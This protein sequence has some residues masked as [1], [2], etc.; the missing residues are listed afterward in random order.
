[1][2]NI[3]IEACW[4]SKSNKQVDC[5]DRG[6]KPTHHDG[7]DSDKKP[8]YHS[9]SPKPKV[10][11]TNNSN[12]IET[13]PKS[14]TPQLVKPYLSLPEKPSSF[15]SAVH[16]IAKLITPD[17]FTTLELAI[18]QDLETRNLHIVLDKLNK[19]LIEPKIGDS[20]LNIQSIA[21]QQ[22]VVEFFVKQALPKPE[23]EEHFLA[24]NTVM[25]SYRTLY[26]KIDAKLAEDYQRL[27]KNF[28]YSPKRVV[29][30]QDRYTKFMN[31]KRF[32]IFKKDLEILDNLI[33]IEKTA[34][35]QESLRM[36]NNVAK[37]FGFVSNAFSIYDLVEAFKEAQR[38]RRW[39]GFFAKFTA[40]ESAILIGALTELALMSSF[41]TLPGAIIIAVMGILAS[42]YFADEQLWKNMIN[43]TQ[44]YLER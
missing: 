20:Q 44:D 16:S 8:N 32:N 19:I 22:G 7:S 30:A 27:M 18:A 37:I 39:D 28:R 1:M 17:N 29:E 11:S 43:H 31:G 23:W 13:K 34:Q 6:N 25:E 36:L 15:N 24:I 2:S 41:V 21:I 4:D 10:N 12:S 14:P 26:S 35:W 33:K 40:F 5:D 9:P 3:S 42:Y 38:T